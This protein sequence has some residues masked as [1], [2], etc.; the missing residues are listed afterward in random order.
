M[1]D[2]AKKNRFPDFVG[3]RSKILEDIR[4]FL[5]VVLLYCLD[6]EDTWKFSR[7]VIATKNLEVLVE[8]L[9]LIHGLYGYPAMSNTGGPSENPGRIFSFQ[10]YYV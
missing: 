2:T 7:D 5:Q 1:D 6:M 10:D 8:S 3:E 9:C 4:Q